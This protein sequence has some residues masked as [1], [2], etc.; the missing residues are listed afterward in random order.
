MSRTPFE[1]R[2]Y[3]LVRKQRESDL[4]NP[5]TVTPARTYV[6]SVQRDTYT[7][8]GKVATRAGAD[9][10]KQHKSIELRAQIEI[11]VGK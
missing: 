9:D 2:Q 1:D 8:P 3:R 6:N 11:R 7:G 5:P 4:A 10:H